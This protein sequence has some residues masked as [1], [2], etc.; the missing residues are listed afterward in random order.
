VLRVTTGRGRK[1]SVGGGISSQRGETPAGG[2]RTRFFMSLG[3][4]SIFFVLSGGGGPAG[5]D[6]YR[7]GG[8]DYLMTHPWWGGGP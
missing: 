8:K 6:R 4:P 5:G 3:G 7:V 2:E 1:E